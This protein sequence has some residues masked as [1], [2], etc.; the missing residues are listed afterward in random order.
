MTIDPEGLLAYLQPFVEP[1]TVDRFPFSRAWLRGQATRVGDPRSASYRLGTQLNLPPSYLLIHRVWLGGVGVLCQLERRHP[2]AA[3]L[4]AGFPASPPRAPPPYRLPRDE[5]RRAPVAA[6][7]RGT[8][9]VAAYAGIARPQRRSR[10]VIT[11]QSGRDRRL[12]RPAARPLTGDDDALQDELAAPHSPR[13][14]PLESAGKALRPDRAVEAQ[15]LRVLDVVGRLG[16]EQLRVV[17]PAWQPV[18]VPLRRGRA[19][20]SCAASCTSFT[21]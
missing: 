8:S 4:I 18:P 12:T 14:V 15:R 20:S 1:A 6:A 5:Q 13:L 21:S 19:R 3:R 2:S 11:G 9:R 17:R 16:E 7:V 10:V